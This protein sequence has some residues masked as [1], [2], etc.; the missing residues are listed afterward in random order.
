[1]GALG[2]WVFASTYKDFSVGLKAGLCGGQPLPHTTLTSKNIG[3]IEE[4]RWEKPDELEK[5]IIC[6]GCDGA[7]P[8]P[9]QLKQVWTAVIS[10]DGC[11]TTSTSVLALD[12][13]I[14]LE[15]DKVKSLSR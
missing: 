5:K 11:I 4:S 12:V 14:T 15:Q 7:E 1:M 13:P 6:A 2:C 8:Q 10:C 9:D 3:V